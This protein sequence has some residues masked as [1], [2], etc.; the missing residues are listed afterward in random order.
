MQYANIDLNPARFFLS[1]LSIEVSGSFFK[2]CRIRIR[3]GSYLTNADDPGLSAGRMIE[4]NRISDLAKISHE[5]AGLV[6]T[7]AEPP[8]FAAVHLQDVINGNFAWLR[9]HQPCIVLKTC[10]NLSTSIY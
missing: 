1:A 9:F 5:V 10:H 8:D 3:F 7:D 4:K 2:L 6:I